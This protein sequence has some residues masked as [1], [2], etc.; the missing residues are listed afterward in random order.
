MNLG[1]IKK[2]IAYFQ[3]EDV[4]LRIRTKERML[5]KKIRNRQLYNKEFTIISNNCWGGMVYESYDLQKQS[6]T[7]GLF[8]MADDYIKFCGDLKGYISKELKFINSY[9][10]KYA[11]I[12]GHDSRFGKYPIGV[13]GDVEIMFLHYHSEKEA[14]EKWEIRCKRIDWD[15]LI[16]KFND[17]NGCSEKQARMFLDLPFENKIFFTIHDDWS[18]IKGEKCC[19]LIPQHTRENYIT[20]SHEPYSRKR[21]FDLTKIINSL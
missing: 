5:L 20:A 21:N 8:F 2:I 6:P 16:V 15:K 11:D 18:S 10:S 1:L 9:N 12:L 19:Y 4:R 13:L 7:V 14:E 17:Q 3:Y